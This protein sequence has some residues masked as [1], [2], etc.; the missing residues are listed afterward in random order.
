MKYSMRRKRK[1]SNKVII[2]IIIAVCIIISIYL[3]SII[4]VPLV[5]TLS[6]KILYGIDATISSIS[7]VITQGTSYFGNM[8]KLNEKVSALEKQLEET[9]ISMQEIN[10]LEVENKDLKKLLSIKEKY[11][12]FEKVYAKVITRSYDNWS[13]EFVIDKGSIDGI[14]EKQTVIAAEGLVG[15]IS[16]VEEKTSTVTTILDPSSAVSIEISNINA[17]AL[18]KGD[19]SLKSKGQVKLTNIPIDTELTEGETV[20]S[21]GIGELYKK[22]IP[23][24]TI[25]EVISRKN[26]IDRYGIIDIFVNIDSLSLVGIIIN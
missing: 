7:G 25:K 5:S 15:Y 6:S 14:K 23:V 12:H 24:G 1:Q 20:Y 26:D 8:K 21:S 2:G 19:Y 17:L 13:E 16:K 18:I 11:R 10:V 3:L 4:R 9:K 22:G